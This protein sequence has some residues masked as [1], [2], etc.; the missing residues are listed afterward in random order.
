MPGKRSGQDPGQHDDQVVAAGQMRPLVGQDGLELG[1]IQAV[2]RS[3][4]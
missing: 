1:L 3:P 4:W 2:Q